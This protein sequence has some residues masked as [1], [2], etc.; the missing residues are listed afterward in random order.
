MVLGIRAIAQRT[1]FNGFRWYRLESAVQKD[2]PQVSG[3]MPN[4][5]LEDLRGGVVLRSRFVSCLV[6]VERDSR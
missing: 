5:P 3:L 1:R 4:P 2:G 6:R